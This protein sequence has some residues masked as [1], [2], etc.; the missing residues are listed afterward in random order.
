MKSPPPRPDPRLLRD[1]RRAVRG[2]V[3]GDA[4]RRGMHATDASFYQQMPIAVVA[5]VDGA[6]V[7]AVLAVARRHSVPVLGRG[8]GTSLAGQTITDGGI[9]LD[10]SRH[11]NRVLEVNVEEQWARVQPGVVRDHLNAALRPHGLMF[12]PETS[13]SNRATIGGMIG[14][15]SSGTMS[16]RYGRTSDHMRSAHALLADGNDAHFGSSKHAPRSAREGELRERLLALVRPHRAYLQRTWPKV[17]RRVG[18][19]SL[20]ELLPEE[21]NFAR[22]LAG[23]EGTL[24]LLTEAVVQLVPVP[25]AIAML[26]LHFDDLLDALRAVPALVAHDPLSVELMDRPLLRLAR[27]NPA[28]GPLCGFLIG[29]PAVVLTLEATGDSIAEAQEQLHRIEA[30]ARAHARSLT[31]ACMVADDATRARI[32]EMRRLSLGVLARMPGPAKPISFIED[33]A[34]PVEHLAD[35]IAA[36]QDACA[37]EGLPT[38]MYGHASVGVLHFKPVLDLKTAKGLGQLDRLSTTAVQLVK[39]FGGSWSGEHGDGI[40]RGAKN[41][42]FWPEK[43]MGL[44]RAVK[45][46]FDPEG[47][48]NPGKIFDTPAVTSHQRYGPTYRAG[49]RALHFHFREE[50]G[51]AAAVELCNGTGACRKLGSGTMCPSYMATREE[52]H[53][54]RGRANALRL[55]MSGQLGPDAMTGDALHDVLDLCLECK[56][57]KSECPSTV[58][59]A[60]MKS[61]VLAAR[62]AE[63]G[64]PLRDRILSSTPMMARL[65]AGPLAPLLNRLNESSP[66]RAVLSRLGVAGERPLPPLTRETFLHWMRRRRSDAMPPTVALFVDTW[67]NCYEPRVGRWFVRLLESR[68][69]RV[70]ALDAGCCGRPLISK[71]RLAEATARG[72][73][74][75]AALDAAARRGLRIAVLEPSCLSALRDDLPDL[76]PQTPAMRR[77]QEALCSGEELLHSI[78]QKHP[79]RVPAS[80]R[81]VL[82]HGHCHQKSCEGTATVRALFRSLSMNCTEIPSGCCGMAGGFGYESEHHELSLRIGEDRLFP[83]VRAATNDTLIAAPGFSCRH[84]IHHGTGRRA[85]HPVELIACA[86]LRR[87]PKR[88]EQQR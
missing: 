15:N 40:A 30:T 35:Y 57:C 72:A 17:L 81:R 34:V 50:G 77:V 55:A 66:A 27:A 65:G 7:A 79:P 26:V 60:K 70:L 84:Q 68:G 86:A 76:L 63:R 42:L 46:L 6:D 9:V 73:R 88:K 56:A 51:F 22:I 33:S 80:S 32:L 21:P 4:V 62:H 69:E 14:N 12:A 24:A 23:S 67:T 28:T 38:L 49:W 29:D 54:T 44:F 48:L 82:L 61:E 41:H 87:L 75:I 45:Q 83:A 3:H 10:F 85:L 47:L 53:S 74:T 58:D 25:P 16:L 52:E 2:G 31:D 13:T 36:L 8:A 39:K 64:L 11:M 19:Y 71:G 78:L 20:D 37:R 59:M 43:T 5:P 18:G 1:L